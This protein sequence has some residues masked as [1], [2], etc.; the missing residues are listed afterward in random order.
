MDVVHDAWPDTGNDAPEQSHPANWLI[1]NREIKAFFVGASWWVIICNY[2]P[3]WSDEME[4][5]LQIIPCYW[6]DSLDELQ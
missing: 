2:E 3:H 6:Q 1:V 4:E 5:M